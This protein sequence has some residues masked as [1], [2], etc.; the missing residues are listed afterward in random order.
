MAEPQWEYK[1]IEN[2]DD[3]ELVERLTTLSADE[4]EAVG[5]TRTPSSDGLLYVA[6]LKRRL[7]RDGRPP[8]AGFGEPV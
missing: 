7:W 6:L 1:I 3:R 5:F 2:T 4:W 8:R